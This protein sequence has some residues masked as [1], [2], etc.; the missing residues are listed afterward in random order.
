LDYLVSALKGLIPLNQRGGNRREAH[1]WEAT[2]YQFFTN[3]GVFIIQHYNFKLRNIHTHVKK[4]KISQVPF[5]A[6][7][8]NYVQKKNLSSGTYL[9]T[10]NVPSTT[11]NFV[12]T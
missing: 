8:Q 3:N 10:K 7:L 2:P 12:R 9:S 11:T 5:T 4:W 1:A 6:K